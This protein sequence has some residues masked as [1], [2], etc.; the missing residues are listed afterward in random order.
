MR[1]PTDTTRRR[2]TEFLHGAITARVIGAA[3]EVY[4]ELGYGFLES[5]Y[6][7]ALEIEFQ[8]RGIPYVREFPLPVIY[9]GRSAGIYRA[10]FLVEGL[11]VVEVKAARVLTDTD[12]SQLLHY[13]KGTQQEV[14]LLLHFGPK[15]DFRRMERSAK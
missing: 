9:K 11:V 13:L 8:L 10:D 2:R 12:R 4:N 3:Y 1:I 7:A 14:G 15:P 6:C 5:V